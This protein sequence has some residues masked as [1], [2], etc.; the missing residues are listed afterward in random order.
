MHPN[1][2][3]YSTISEVAKPSHQIFLKLCCRL[4]A[5]ER[6]SDMKACMAQRCIIQFFDTEMIS[7]ID[8]HLCLINVYRD[9]TVDMNRV[10]TVSN[11]FQQR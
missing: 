8:I 10:K 7:L 2:L 9:Q 5:G 1:L 11:A 6:T 3:Y 4:Q